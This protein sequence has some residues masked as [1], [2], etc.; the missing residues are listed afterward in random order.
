MRKIKVKRLLYIINCGKKFNE[1]KNLLKDQDWTISNHRKLDKLWLDK[2]ENFYEE[3]LNFN[4]R[5][6]K[7]GLSKV[8]C[9][10]S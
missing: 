6:F 5:E 1:Q 4:N 2:N 10:L 3:L 8:N 7:K 9:K